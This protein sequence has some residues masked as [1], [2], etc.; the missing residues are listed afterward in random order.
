METLVSL[1][2]DVYEELLDDRRNFWDDG[3]HREIPECIWDWVLETLREAGGLP[4]P[5]G[6]D[7]RYIVDNLIVNGS[8]EDFEDLRRHYDD[9][10]GMTDDEIAD[11]IEEEGRAC[12]V[13]REERLVLWNTGL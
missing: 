7:P 8:W 3:G 6:N 1:P 12:A 2:R 10:S 11:L 5:R 4:D 13:F 9:Y